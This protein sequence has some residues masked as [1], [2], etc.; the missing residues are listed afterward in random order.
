MNGAALRIARR[1][2]AGGLRGFWVY[3]A[4]LA[5]GTAAIAAS[6][7]VT[8]TFTRGLAGEARTLLGGDAM[9]TA[10]QRRA[11]PEEMAF[12][13][14]LGAVAERVD[15]NV[16]ATAGDRR[17]QVDVIGV[18]SG[19]PLVGAV[20][21]SG[22]TGGLESALA[23]EG[24]RW[25]AVVTQSFLDAFDVEIG[26]PVTLGPIRAEVRAR[27]D[28][29]PDRV[30]A[31]GAF[32]PEALVQI[33]G[34][35]EAERL[36][37]GQLFRSQRLVVFDD[38]Q[39]LAPVAEAF[40]KAFGAGGLRVR[41]PEDAVDGL[42]A[43]LDTLNDFLAIVG[44][45]ALVAGGVGVAQATGAFLE[46]RTGSIAALKALGAESDLIR[47]AYLWQLGVLAIAGAL[48]GVMIGA[49]VPFLINAIAGASIPLPQALGVYP[50]PLLKAL[51]LGVLAAAVFAL[52]ALGRARATRATALFRQLGEEERTGT[53]AFER[54]L[55]LLAAVLLAGLAI[56]TSGRPW[57]TAILLAG[58]LVAWGLFL[59]AAYGIR[60]LARASARNAK[61]LWRLTLANLGGIG[62]LAPT[63]VP[64][65]GLGLALLTLVASVQ[66]NLLR[67]ISETAPSNAPS[68]VFTQ[69]PM[70]GIEAFD[71]VLA[72]AGVDV[73][74]PDRF[75]R[76]PFMLVRVTA[77]GGQPL[78]VSSVS[79]S[80]RWVVDG[81]TSV[82]FLDA[83]PPE[84]ELV[85]GDWWPSGYRGSLLVSIEADAAAGLG[86]EIG[87][88]I[89]FNVFGRE[90]TAEVASLRRVDWGT[91]GIGS[92]T[93]FIFSPGTLE[94][95]KP[96]HVAIAMADAGAEGT[97]IDELGDR[98]PEVVV[99]QT[100]PALAAAAEVFGN[101]AIA[102]NAVASVVTVAGLLVLM[103]AFAAMARKRRAETAV[104]KTFGAERGAVLRLY[105]GEFAL[106]G[107]A[108]A[109]IGAALGVGA[110]YPI[111]VQV[112][113]AQ[114][115]WPVS[116]VGA[117]VALAVGIS[118][119]GGAAVGWRT[120]SQPP[121]RVVR[122]V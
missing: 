30:G 62:S 74:D 97:I 38:G 28:G 7:A 55:S 103:G 60:T 121:M 85:A 92:N 56:A 88:T 16:M 67:Q 26:D 71:T 19:Y 70:D 78:D 47:T 93:P 10:A 59:L 99:F 86:L 57:L 31:P 83:Q 39:S 1:E 18:D 102:V 63:I 8:E 43:L 122:G 35:L 108:G 50:L 112:F 3:L 109:L 111:V 44:I 53:P 68:L 100:R 72:E 82:T 48:V 73:D 45:A 9:F 80:E 20:A 113:E 23:L 37:N 106:A 81:E 118:A 21:L 22:G 94:A 34:L 17:R 4:C 5:L 41:G 36:V 116:E 11:T 58:A 115:T 119:F 6:G 32:G 79:E 105:A 107:A 101:I 14:P 64:A 76:A 54:G 66:A 33:D 29:L 51:A 65:L 117:L 96:Y 25:G 52:P 91:F 12:I 114:W 46:S 120:L 110:A 84:A 49:V 27:L 87:D 77:L 98:L 69:I 2:L 75:R 61:G 95:A 40:E 90:V 13:D 42:Q 89:G 24:D 15:L 104:L